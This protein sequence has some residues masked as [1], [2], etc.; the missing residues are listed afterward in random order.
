MQTVRHQKQ[1]K[2]CSNKI[3]QS[4]FPQKLP[5]NQLCWEVRLKS[6][7]PAIA[8]WTMEEH[9]KFLA[10]REKT[11]D[12]PAESPQNVYH[13]WCFKHPHSDQNSSPEMVPPEILRPILCGPQP[14]MPMMNHA[15]RRPK[16]ASEC[17][18]RWRLRGLKAERRRLWS[19]VL[20]LQATQ[21]SLESIQMQ[22]VLNPSKT[23]KL[24]HLKAF[25]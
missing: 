12:H 17:C 15:T 6:N 14:S 5:K 8:L 19:L 20:L 23:S 16:Q 10:H 21:P 24:V 3:L 18:L 7:W 2:S 13:L 9:W 1:H 25:V 11:F 4:W 22:K